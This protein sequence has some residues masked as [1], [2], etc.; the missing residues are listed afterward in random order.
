MCSPTRHVTCPPNHG[1]LVSPFNLFLSVA[2]GISVHL[3]RY[4]IFRALFQLRLTAISNFQVLCVTNV[5][6][7]KN[8]NRISYLKCL[9]Q[10]YNH[11]G[12]RAIKNFE[13]GVWGILKVCQ[14]PLPMYPNTEIHIWF[15]GNGYIT[16]YIWNVE[17]F[18]CRIFVFFLINFNI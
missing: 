2:M 6:L 15:A 13:V 16:S 4:L 11:Y 5:G 18:C 7:F 3:P 9:E 17:F 14:I 12:T 1:G 8:L 10:H